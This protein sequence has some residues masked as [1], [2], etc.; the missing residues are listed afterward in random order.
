LP[1]SAAPPGGDRA[2]DDYVS[3]AA[4][5]T[6]NMTQQLE[7]VIPDD[8][9]RK[10]IEELDAP[11]AFTILVITADDSWPHVAMVSRG[12]VV[13]GDERLLGVALWPA[14]TA[15]R[16]LTDTGRATL[17]F[18][19]AGTAYTLRIQAVRLSD[20]SPSVGPSLACFRAS[21]E[22]VTGDRPAYAVLESG[23]QFSL[24]DPVVT[25]PRWQ[26]A[27]SALLAAIA[28]GMESSS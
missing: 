23:V 27:R 13:Y 25:M 28:P 9:R 3:A 1:V 10:L 11:D 4:R 2:G 12:E 15:C 21:V 26:A 18:V 14:S 8:L 6:G 19:L 20:L 22:G 24:V 16:N 5:D 17:A 7:T